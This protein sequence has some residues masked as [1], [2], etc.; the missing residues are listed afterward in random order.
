[1]V[2]IGDFENKKGEDY[3]DL[4]RTESESDDVP[5]PA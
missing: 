2:D 1:V 3:I 4:K 5:V